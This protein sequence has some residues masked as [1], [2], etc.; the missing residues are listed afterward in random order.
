LPSKEYDW[1]YETT[2]DNP[3]AV[4]VDLSGDVLT[5]PLVNVEKQ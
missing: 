5:I 4:R 2:K 1:F 3:V